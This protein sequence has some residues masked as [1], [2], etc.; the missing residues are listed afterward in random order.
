MRHD[1]RLAAAAAS[2]VGE[3]MLEDAA[4]QV[5]LELFDDEVRQAAGWLGPLD[6]GRPVLLDE[7][8]Q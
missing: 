2:K 1:R 5:C 6:E 3:A 4:A 8:V 7:L